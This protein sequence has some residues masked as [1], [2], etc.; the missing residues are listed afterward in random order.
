MWRQEEKVKEEKKKK[1][2][3]NTKEE[4]DRGGD[5]D[6]DYDY[7]YDKNVKCHRG[8]RGGGGQCSQ[9]EE[10]TTTSQDNTLPVRAVR[11]VSG[12]GVRT[13]A[14]KKTGRNDC[15]NDYCSSVRQVNP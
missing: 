6:D 5:D 11:E 4:D 3:N 13:D 14:L 12:K 15:P 7:D 9:W 8:K 1:K 10:T 2:D